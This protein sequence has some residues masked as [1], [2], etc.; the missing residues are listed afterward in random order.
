MVK[1]VALGARAVMIG[2][3]YLWGL[4]AN[5]QA[6][7]ENVLD[8]LRGGIDSA[9]LGLGH[10]TIH[11]LTPDDLVIPPGFTRT[12]GV[13]DR[14]PAVTRP[15]QPARMTVRTGQRPRPAPP[16]GPRRRLSV[17]EHA[18]VLG[19]ATGMRSTVALAALI[20]RRSDGLP[21]VL[22]HPAARWI[23]A[24]ADGAE[25]VVDKLPGTPSR[26][27]P[28]GLTGR[29]IS[30]S[31][32]AAVLARSEHRGPIPSMLTA[33]V[34]AL[35][36]AK[37]CHDARAALARRLPDPVVA[38]AEDALAIGLTAIGSG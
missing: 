21:A 19:A 9:L 6:G 16:R 31:L 36:A 15:R 27:D 26:L 2:R 24:T 32:A 28:P 38:V 8:I 14:A 33:S 29:L 22:R 4:A 37:I 17:L 1:A 35:A 13:T 23:A 12:L 20:F 10:S 7:V 11:D 18:A 25:L 34:A 5:G 30:A 3:A